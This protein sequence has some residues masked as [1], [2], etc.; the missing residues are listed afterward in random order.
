MI[1]RFSVGSL[2]VDLRA[3][4]DVL[5]NIDMDKREGLGQVGDR[6]GIS[7]VKSFLPLLTL[8]TNVVDICE[9]IEK[10]CSVRRR[11][12]FLASW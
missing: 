7:V 10:R 3:G 6:P 11:R 2:V 9:V 5:V 12:S 1:E 8:K 4:P